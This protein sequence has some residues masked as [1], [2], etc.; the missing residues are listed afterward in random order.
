MRIPPLL[1]LGTGACGGAQAILYN[2]GR[3]N[4]W[5]T[6][7]AYLAGTSPFL[8][9]RLK[10]IC[11]TTPTKFRV[12]PSHLL[13]STLVAQGLFYGFGRAMGSLYMKASH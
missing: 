7:T 9:L 2:K 1:L 12:G 3:Y 8:Y 6:V 13:A 11:E 5:P 10:D 4:E